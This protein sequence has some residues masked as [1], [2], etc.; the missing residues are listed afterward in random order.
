MEHSKAGLPTR[1]TQHCETDPPS[2]VEQVPF[3][4][5]GPYH[6]S[7]LHGNWAIRFGVLGSSQLVKQQRVVRLR[8]PR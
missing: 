2:V 5:K 8:L 4:I 6:G 1:E 7:K 3:D